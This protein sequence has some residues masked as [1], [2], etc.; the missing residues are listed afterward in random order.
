MSVPGF[1]KWGSSIPG[2][3]S[4]GLYFI[5]DFDG[6]GAD[7]I[8][9]VKKAD[10]SD[11]TKWNIVSGRIGG[12]ISQ[13]W[14]RELLGWPHN[15]RFFIGDFDGDGADDIAFVKKADNSNWAVWHIVSGRTGGPI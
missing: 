8:A 2:W 1:P 4:E 9:F 5:G 14:G 10:K 11:G 12:P 13:W 7:D 3:P 15:G 6:D